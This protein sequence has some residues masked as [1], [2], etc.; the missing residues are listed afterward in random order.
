MKRALTVLL[1][2][3]VF[4]SVVS[5]AMAVETKSRV[6]SKNIIETRLGEMN[7][8][9]SNTAEIVVHREKYEILVKPM[10]SRTENLY[11]VEILNSKGEVVWRGVSEI[12]PIE[13]LKN[14][15]YSVSGPEPAAIV[16]LTDDNSCSIVPEYGLVCGS[17]KLLVWR[18]LH[19]SGY[20]KQVVLSVT[21]DNPG[22]FRFEA[23]MAI[24]DGI[25]GWGDASSDSFT[26]S[27]T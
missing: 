3:V 8:I 23:G 15:Q 14:G 2:L 5:P 16:Q 7:I 27:V 20:Q 24:V 25:I 12:N 9:N 17:G 22:N 1:I 10:N 4:G 13:Y 26:V 19:W 6:S 21:Y 11:M 18:A